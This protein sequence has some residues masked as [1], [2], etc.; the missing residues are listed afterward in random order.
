MYVLPVLFALAHPLPAASRLCPGPVVHSFIPGKCKPMGYFC[1]LAR[2]QVAVCNTALSCC[3]QVNCLSCPARTAA[4]QGRYSAPSPEPARCQGC[5]RHQELAVSTQL[6][7]L[8]WHDTGENPHIQETRLFYPMAAI[9]R[10]FIAQEPHTG[11]VLPMGKLRQGQQ[12][13]VST[14]SPAAAHN[15]ALQSVER[16]AFGCCSHTT[17]PCDTGTPRTEG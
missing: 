6:L 10:I 11:P 8:M 3:W 15:R 7:L 13:E 17:R 5:V 12:R 2:R 4:P 14:R 1:L 9:R 16:G